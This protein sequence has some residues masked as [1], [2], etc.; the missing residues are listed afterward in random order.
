MHTPWPRIP[1]PLPLLLSAALLAPLAG[2]AAPEAP[3]TLKLSAAQVRQ[4]GIQTAL[5]AADGAASTLTLSGT[6]ALPPQAAVLVSAPMAGVVQSVLVDLADGVRAGQPLLRLHS[7]ELAG[8]Q[9]EYLQLRL[10]ATQAADRLRR[11]EQLFTDGVIAESR[12]RETRY[13]EQQARVAA[14]E[15]RQALRLAGVDE[16]QLQGLVDRL[17]VQ[18]G[19]TLAAPAAGRVAEV[20]AQP[21]QQVAAGAPLLR[22]ARPAALTLLLQATP[23]QAAQLRPGAAVQ[24]EDCAATGRVRGT[25][26]AM[27]GSSQAV[28][29]QVQLERPVDCVQANQAVRARVAS[30][31]ASGGAVRIPAEALL[32]LDGRS[33]V[34]VATADGFRPQAVRLLSQSGAQA[35]VEGLAPQAAVVVRGVAA[36]KG[37]WA[38]LGEVQ[39]AAAGA[40]AASAATPAT[41]AR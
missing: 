14:D 28:L 9:R 18:P 8:T 38:G 39:P 27:Q 5:P 17:A 25:V 41:G 23:A 4:A 26:P 20:L 6:A 24:V 36:L 2:R 15:R 3:L 11:D 12:L 31:G 19:L 1:R 7:A 10:Q 33:Q 13:A 37:A 22:L 34:F 35:L 16:R 32:Q 21:G 29:I 30:A 40:S